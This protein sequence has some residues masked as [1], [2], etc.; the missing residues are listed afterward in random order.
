MLERLLG[1][2]TEIPIYV[3]GGAVRDLFLELPTRDFDILLPEQGFMVH[4]AGVTKALG[5]EPYALNQEHKLWRY[6]RLGTVLD[7][8][9]VGDDLECNLR[10]RDFT[11]NS[12]AL[13][14]NNYIQR[15]L[16]QVID[17]TGGLDALSKRILGPSSPRSLSDD[18]V[19]ILRA[20]RFQGELGFSTSP[21]LDAQAEQTAHALHTSPGERVWAELYRIV[22]CTNAPELFDWLDST[23]A[24]GAILPELITEKGVE[25]NQYH[26]FCVFEHSR[27]AFR[28]YLDLWERADFL[29]ADLQDNV[30]AE[31]HGMDPR[32]QAICRLGALLHDIGKPKAKAFKDDGRVTFYRHEQIGAEM[33]PYIVQRLRLSN[34]EGR[35][36]GRFVRW[37]TYLA[38][39]A[40]QPRLTEAH[41]HRIG[42]RLGPYSVPIALFNIADLLAKGEDMT[43]D[44][45]YEQMVFAVGRFLHAWY[46]QHAEVI[47]PT[48]PLNGAE[49]AVQLGLPPGRWLNDTLTYLS[50]QAAMGRVGDRESAVKMARDYYRHMP[51]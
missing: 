24:L 19:R 18:P 47:N 10:N 35:A 16:D 39:L 15:S 37:H 41:L 5:Q 48:L 26:S 2:S 30:R 17:P 3:V 43:N 4:L 46:Y 44:K 31:L 50:E 8:A 29:E 25:Q 23:G 21:V 20:A 38:Q 51:R 22:N 32:M 40:R 28:A 27:R 42:R 12:M 13:S 49:L 9:P 6:E 7:V 45:S 14:L 33:T 1:L 34:I 11:V 36:L